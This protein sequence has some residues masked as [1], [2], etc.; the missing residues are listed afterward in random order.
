MLGNGFQC[1]RLCSF[2]WKFAF[3]YGIVC[4]ACKSRSN[5]PVF[6]QWWVLG[7]Q[8]PTHRTDNHSVCDP[9]VDMNKDLT[10]LLSMSGIGVNVLC[11]TCE[12]L[13]SA[14]PMHGRCYPGVNT[15]IIHLSCPWPPT[16]WDWW[17]QQVG[18]W[19]RLQARGCPFWI[20]SS[21]GLQVLFLQWAWPCWTSLTWVVL[22]WAD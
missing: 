14:H 16:A 17:A 18:G 11:H 7:V 22:T 5:L 15:R 13:L 8:F 2:G 20:C 12:Y 10:V 6:F 1:W 19:T 21:W 3:L 9:S 4:I